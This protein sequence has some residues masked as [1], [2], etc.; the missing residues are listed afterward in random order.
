MRRCISSLVLRDGRTN[1]FIWLWARRPHTFTSP[2]QAIEM[3]QMKYDKHERSVISCEWTWGRARLALLPKLDIVGKSH[4]HTLTRAN[5]SSPCTCE[6]NAIN[7]K[8][9]N[10][11]TS[12][13][14]HIHIIIA[15]ALFFSPL[16]LLSHFFSFSDRLTVIISHFSLSSAAVAGFMRAFRFCFYFQFPLKKKFCFSVSTCV[17][18]SASHSVT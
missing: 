13:E 12:S 6:S 8:N 1:W 5:K 7:N 11:N 17:F 4:R 14:I 18:C 16:F 10:D 3:F 2:P 15:V 9:Y